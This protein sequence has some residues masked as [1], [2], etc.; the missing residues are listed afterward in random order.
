MELEIGCR[1]YEEPVHVQCAEQNDSQVLEFLCNMLVLLILFFNEQNRP[2]VLLPKKNDVGGVRSVCVCASPFPMPF[3][4]VILEYL[5][6]S[7][8]P[9]LPPPS[10]SKAF[11]SLSP[12]IHVTF[13][14]TSLEKHCRPPPLSSFVKPLRRQKRKHE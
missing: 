4:I 13:D 5:S 10:Q 9:S 1:C 6:F 7:V 14:S 8:A 3:L 11:G 2:D 12:V